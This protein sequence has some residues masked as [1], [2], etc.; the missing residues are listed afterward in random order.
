MTRYNFGDVLLLECGD[1]GTATAKRPAVVLYDNGDPDILVCA[2]SG[3]P[4]FTP[5][6]FKVASWKDAGLLRPSYVRPAK[7]AGLSKYRINRKIGMLGAEDSWW[8][9][10]VLRRMFDE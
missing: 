1:D 6:D 2:V 7:L 4:C 9:K 8:L 3:K 10:K 5:T